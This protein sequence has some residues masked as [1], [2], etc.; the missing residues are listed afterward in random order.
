MSEGAITST[1]AKAIAAL[2]SPDCHTNEQAARRAGV[3]LRTLARWLA[4][5]TA[6][7]EAL[8]QAQADMIARS[9]MRLVALTDAAIVSLA[10]ALDGPYQ[11]GIRAAA[12]ILEQ[13]AKYRDLTALEDRIAALEAR[14]DDHKD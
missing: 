6:F 10:E 8:A 7:R 1:Q 14:T 4:E 5:D 3:S 9:A 12:L 13:A 2:M 11:Y